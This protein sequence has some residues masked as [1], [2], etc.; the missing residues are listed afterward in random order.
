MEKKGASNGRIFRS[1]PLRPPAN[2]DCLRI[3]L[4]SGQDLQQMILQMIKYNQLGIISFVFL[5]YCDT[6][7]IFFKLK[8]K[9]FPL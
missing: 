8:S 7:I 9:R 3:R 6:A 5:I 4:L 1:P 2:S